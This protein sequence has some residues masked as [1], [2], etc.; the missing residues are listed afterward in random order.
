MLRGFG[1]G[2]HIRPQVVWVNPEAATPPEDDDELDVEVQAH[3]M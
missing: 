2:T 1:F 3:G